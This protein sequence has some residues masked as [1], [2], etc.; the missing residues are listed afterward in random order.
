MVI[1]VDVCRYHEKI[2][3]NGRNQKLTAE[4]CQN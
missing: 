1:T 4:I 2:E 3:E